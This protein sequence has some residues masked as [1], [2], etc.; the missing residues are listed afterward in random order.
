MAA[1]DRFFLRLRYVFLA[2]FAIGCVGSFA[3]HYFWKW[4]E[5]RC[6]SAPNNDWDWRERVCARR[7]IITDITGRPAK[8]VIAERR[9]REALARAAGNTAP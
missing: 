5:Q 8:D 6:L 2:I 1:M 4:P 7:V 3:Y 9:A